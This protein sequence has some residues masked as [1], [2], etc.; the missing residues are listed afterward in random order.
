[1]YPPLPPAPSIGA[2]PSGGVQAPGPPP[3]A[4]GSHSVEVPLQAGYH[5]NVV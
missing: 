1:M 5:L 2:Q 4:Q 3:E